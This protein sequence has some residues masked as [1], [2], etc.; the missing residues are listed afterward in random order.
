VLLHVARPPR[1]CPS[2]FTVHV[3]QRGNNRGAMFQDEFDYRLFLW[4]LGRESACHRVAVHGY[5]LMTNHV[6]LMA[7]PGDPRSL[8]RLMQGIGRT[9][10]PVFNR[11]HERSGGLWEGRYRS[12]TISS[13]RYWLTCLRYVELNPVRAGL[14][15]VPEHY[16]W[17]SARAHMIGQPDPILS[18][19]DLY[20][21]LAAT[22]ADRLRAGSAM[23]S[24]PAPHHAL[25]DIRAAVK[26]GRWGQTPRHGSTQGV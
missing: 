26:S 5:V 7:T 10:V 25:A 4:L 14:V 21:R 6:H 11:R 18:D 16:R 2:G 8:S 22:S 15:P 23:C 24:I 12:F 3:V 1:I 20:L 17:S 19:H 13:E 9:Y